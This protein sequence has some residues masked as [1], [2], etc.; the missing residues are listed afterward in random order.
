[1]QTNKQTGKLAAS[2]KALHGHRAV[3]ESATT[4][5]LCNSADTQNILKVKVKVKEVFDMLT[6]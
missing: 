3:L 4:V 6:S 2:G 5:S 1:M